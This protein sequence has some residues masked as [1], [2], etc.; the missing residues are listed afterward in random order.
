[1]AAIRQGHLLRG[2]EAPALA[3]TMVKAAIKGLK[4]K[5]S[6]NETPIAVMTLKLL[7]KARDKLKNLRLPA[8]RKRVIWS[9]LTLLFLGSFR[10]GSSWL[11]TASAMIL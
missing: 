5:E 7:E 6:L 8:E 10:G 1:M 9:I 4:N 2:L 11:Q 3:D